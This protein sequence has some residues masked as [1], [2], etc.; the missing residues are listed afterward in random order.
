[1]SEQPKNDASGEGFRTPVPRVLARFPDVEA[2]EKPEETVE[3]LAG[4]DGRI[5]NQKLATRVLLGVAVVLLLVAV[6]PLVFQRKGGEP[7]SGDAAS[8]KPAWEPEN[9]AP[10]ASAAPAWGGAAGAVSP[11]G[12][13]DG[14]ARV[15]ALPEVDYRGAGESSRMPAMPAAAGVA[16]DASGAGAWEQASLANRGQ[17]LGPAEESRGVDARRQAAIGGDGRDSGY[18]SQYTATNQPSAI[19]G[20]PS[21]AGGYRGDH[22]SGQA[23]AGYRPDYAA[24]VYAEQSGGYR[25]PIR[26]DSRPAAYQEPIPSHQAYRDDSRTGAW[27]EPA[28]RSTQADAGAQQGYAAQ[29]SAG[30]AGQSGYYG[31]AGGD[32]RQAPA[33]DYRYP[34][35]TADYRANPAADYSAEPPR[36]DYRE[37]WQNQPPRQQYGNGGYGQDPG[38]YRSTSGY[39]DDAGASLAPAQGA[40]YYQADRRY[41]ANGRNAPYEA[42]PGA[43]QFQGTIEQAPVSSGS[44]LY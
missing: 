7:H 40:P 11:P 15:E 36:P 16:A 29:P 33:A 18:H 1:M 38:M 26:D 23:G 32:Y 39:R 31:P 21:Y 12:F 17:S 8:A 9:P 6:L 34:S 35:Q 42:Q 22:P 41:E 5:V 4:L 14:G 13:P 19:S 25:A 30:G 28:Y 27:Q 37:T 43:A 44:R 10:L 20:D 2:G 24:G 3:P